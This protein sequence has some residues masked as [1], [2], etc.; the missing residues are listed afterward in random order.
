MQ[1]ITLQTNDIVISSGDSLGQLQFAASAESDGGASRY[2]VGRIFA[3]GEGAF[4]ASSNPASIVFATSDADNL[5]ASG[6]LKISHD[7]NLLPLQDSAYDIGSTNFYFDDLYVNSGIFRD[8]VTINGVDVSVDGHTHTSSD[9]TDFATSVSG[10]LPVL[11]V[12][13][14]SAISVVNNSGDFVVSVSGDLSELNDV[15]TSGVVD[16]NLLV[17][18]SGADYWEPSSGLYYV[19]DSLGIGTS[20]PN[21]TLHAYSDTP[22]GTVLNVEGTNGSLFSVVD[23]LSGTLM[24]VNTIAGLPVFQVNSDYS[25]VGG[26]FNQND[27]NITAGGDIGIGTATPSGKLHVESGGVAAMIGPYNS[28]T[29]GGKLRVYGDDTDTQSQ[30]IKAFVSRSGVG[31]NI[32]LNGTSYTTGGN[33]LGTNIGMYGYAGNGNKN[34]AFYGDAGYNF[35]RDRVGIGDADPDY[36][37]DVAGTGNF[38]GD[39]YAGG[40][41]GIGTASPL[42]PLH[43]SKDGGASTV[44][45]ASFQNANATYSQS[46]DLKMDTSK[47]ITWDGGSSYG[48][49]FSDAG[50]QGF[51]WLING[52][53]IVNF[54]G[55]GKVGIGT[56]DPTTLLDVSGVI[57]ATGG[58]ST[59][60]NEAYDWIQNSGLDGTGSASGVAFW[61]DSNTLSNDS[62]L[63]WDSTN[64]RLGI[65]ISAP[66]GIF[67]I[68]GGVGSD[69]SQITLTTVGVTTTTHFGV[70]NSD[71]RPFLA[72][73]NG[74]LS[75]SIY[76]WG[77][78][79]RGTNGDLQI[80]RKNNSTSWT[81]VL[82]IQR[83]NGNVGI[84]LTNPSEKLDVSGNANISGHLSASTKSFL[85]NHPTK[86]G[87]KLQYG[88]LE[89]PYHGVRLTGRDS[90]K[91]GVCIVKLP[92]YMKKLVKEDDINIQITNYKHAKT[93]YVEDIDL[94]KNCFV[95]KGHRCKTLGQL[96]FFWTFTA[97]RKDVPDLIVEK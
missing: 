46:I 61:T 90:L 57:T 25:I 79:D 97:V 62:A 40:N 38:T 7:G 65:G 17:W 53:G 20:S 32:C 93:L 47:N 36:L 12:S 56:S 3:Q 22:S 8:G 11:N 2:V 15:D 72:S 42:Y 21:A 44:I 34:Y 91:D 77:F 64:N 74:N 30:A 19:N 60:W 92:S 27:F 6:K 96:E 41:V 9:I 23:N 89:S 37:L 54:K 81:D 49:I 14:G 59:E 28:W 87:K 95:V 69:Y 58:N 55:D 82:T 67:H 13:A 66:S 71:T 50:T 76:G 5:P 33:G 51:G 52:S 16:N 4:S 70:G 83:N 29:N 73:L 78:F 1:S 48:G 18:N 88:S 45:L 43:V 85:I 35:F 94:E 31:L 63:I 24:S 68:N 10:L 39:I 75:S 26:R 84:G 86:E 80:K